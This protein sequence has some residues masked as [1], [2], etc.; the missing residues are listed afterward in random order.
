MTLW[1]LQEAYEL[2]RWMHLTYAGGS[3]ADCPPFVAPGA[4][5][6]HRGRAEAQAGANRS[7]WHGWPP[8]KS[9]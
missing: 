3:M 4:D 8:R 6:R 7:S 2:G 5:R 1:L 9:R